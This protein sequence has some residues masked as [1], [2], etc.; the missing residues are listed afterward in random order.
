[1]KEKIKQFFCG[2]VGHGRASAEVSG[3]NG[4]I[5]AHTYCPD[6]KKT[7]ALFIAPEA[8]E[9]QKEFVLKKI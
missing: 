1:V 8:T 5:A 2:L 3:E 9:Q 4:T 6:C 7:I